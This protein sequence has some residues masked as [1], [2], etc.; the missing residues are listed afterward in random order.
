MKPRHSLRKHVQ[1]VRTAGGWNFLKLTC[2]VLRQLQYDGHWKT[3]VT[4][5]LMRPDDMNGEYEDWG[6]VLRGQSVRR[7][8]DP[9][10][11]NR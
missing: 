3:P 1:V 6:V 11:W 9:L 10:K 4:L 2:R 7:L 5:R 8:L